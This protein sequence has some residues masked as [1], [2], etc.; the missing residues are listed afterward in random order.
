VNLPSLIIGL[1]TDVL[2]YNENERERVLNAI[3][4]EGRFTGEIWNKDNK[5][6]SFLTYLSATSLKDHS[7]NVIGAMGISR[8]ITELKEAEEQLRK[9]EEKYRAIYD[10]AY[11]G[12]AQVD[13]EG[14]F[15]NTNQQLCSITGYSEEE[16]RSMNFQD[17]TVP[18]DQKKSEGFREGLQKQN[19]E[20]IS[21]EKQYIHK[22]GSR[23]DMNVTVALVK[24]KSG[25]PA[26]FVTVFEDITERKRNEQELIRSLKEK[27]V[28]LREVHHRVKN[29]LQ[30]ISSI[31][32]LQSN[33]VEDPNTLQILRES[34]NRI[35]S[36]SFI[37]ESLYRKDEFDSIDLAQYVKDL[38][39]N[40]LHSYHS[41]GTDIRL[42]H[43]L[44]NV[45][46]DLDQAIPCGLILNELVSNALKYA[47]PD[48][49][50]GLVHI[51]VEQEQNTDATTLVRIR[52]QDDGVGLPEGYEVGASDS[53]G[54]QLV[55]SLLEQIGGEIRLKR[56]NGTEYL[57]TFEKN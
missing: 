21:F 18:E 16:F 12:I 17:I 51:G 56:D 32:N 39:T 41:S 7:G 22:N 40:L 4:K 28:L 55:S 38:T 3:Y 20:R 11:I 47:F 15:L 24:D 49:D 27:E 31:L 37:H 1:Q 2:F 8:D 9:S 29:N 48:R 52:V 42:E 10:Q 5:G 53:L 54:L 6:R 50:R 36:M 44:E 57:I 35:N 45:E 23:I 13:L 14:N 25:E 34:Q 30:V 33:F 43:D 19:E 26:Y 46:L